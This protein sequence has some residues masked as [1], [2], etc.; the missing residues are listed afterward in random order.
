LRRAAVTQAGGGGT[1]YRVSRVLPHPD[2]AFN[3]GDVS[4]PNDVAL[5]FLTACATLGAA[6]QPIALAT[7][8]GA[9]GGAGGDARRP[10]RL[11]I[12][13]LG[14]SGNHYHRAHDQM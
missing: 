1:F 7:P 4:D 14:P 6:V 9:A 12:R 10:V 3:A 8:A 2:W 11:S 13:T 5:L